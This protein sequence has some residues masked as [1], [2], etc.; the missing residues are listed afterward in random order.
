MDRVGSKFFPALV[1]GGLLL[2][3]LAMAYIGQYSRYMADDYCTTARALSDGVLG[4]V[5]WWYT[6]WAG[7]FTNWTLKGLAAY[8]GTGLTGVLPALV[9]LSWTL[10]AVWALYQTMLVVRL[11]QPRISAAV[12][13]TLL[14]FAVFDGTPSVIQSLYWLGAVI[15]YT[16]PMIGLTFLTGFLIHT[17]RRQPARVTPGAVAV[18]ALVTFIAGGLSEVYVALQTA[19]LG[20]AFLAALVAE[21]PTYRRSALMLLGVGIACSLLALLIMA[22]APGNAVRRAEFPPM[23]LP[24]AI[25]QTL[26]TSLAYPF[27]AAQRFSTTALPVAVLLPLLYIYRLEPLPAHLRLSAR[28]VRRLL[29]VV[30]AVALLLTM[31]CLLPPIY[32][33][34][35][36]PASRAYIMPQF[37]L[38]AAAAACGSI[39]GLGA[40]WQRPRLSSPA[41][42][43]TGAATVILLL[44]GPV[45]STWKALAEAPDFR[46]YATE[47]DQRDA[48]IRAA[49]AS[50]EQ[51]IETEILA[52]DI[53]A[54]AGLESIGPDASGSIN[55]CAAQYYGVA[56]LAARPPLQMGDK[57]S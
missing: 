33:T 22:A 31:A 9:L 5:V 13:S 7:Q 29:L 6:N 35:Y 24:A 38:I 39:I 49:A 23:P 48:M 30:A 18:V 42:Q 51:T 32:A 44:I 46:T 11:P 12:F 3:L 37:I 25:G 40:R 17:L 41:L 19:A 52:V 28:K 15:P 14:I 36:A 21:P 55:T 26:I 47:W 2:P 10:V 27:I 8:L 4:S 16:L 50:G 34:S 20:L 57:D 53:G 45:L 56:S 54:R 1:L 43:I